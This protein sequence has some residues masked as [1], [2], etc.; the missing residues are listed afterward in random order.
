MKTNYH[1]HTT[2]CQHAYGTDEEYVL[3]ALKG[4][5]QLL[6]F[7]DHA[8][9]KYRSD[10]L[11]GIRMQPEELPGYVQSLQQLRT[12]YQ[13]QIAL[14][15]GLECEYF[16][17]YMYWMKEQIKEYRLDFVIFGNHFYHTDEKFPYFGRHTDSRDM[18][19][20]YEE[21][22]IEGIESGLF[23][24]L[25]HPDLFMRSYPGWD[26]H[27]SNVSRH[28][29]RAAARHGLPLEYNIGRWILGETGD[30]ATY[31]APQFWHIAANEGCTA[32]IGLDAHDNLDLETSGLYE[33]AVRQ[34]RELKIPRI[35]TLPPLSI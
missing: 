18:L 31:P 22:A 21:S 23:S 19:D 24:C 8:P 10:Y 26:H 33:E 32:I 35:E 12:K 13:A 20:L 14:K 9:W 3:S 4:G 1:T 6:G 5:Y 30:R 29:C 34:L 11:S 15:I 17:D 2:R 27:C 28:I 16:P 25:A 7:S